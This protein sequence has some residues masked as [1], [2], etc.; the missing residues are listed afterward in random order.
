MLYINVCVGVCW[1][2]CVIYYERRPTTHTHTPTHPPYPPG[3]L[4]PPPPLPP[5]LRPWNSPP[6]P[7]RYVSN[8]SL[9]NR[10]MRF[11]VNRNRQIILL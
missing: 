4:P 1:S 8:S 10:I 3:T 7:L 11:V 9:T 6:P 5:P 2:E